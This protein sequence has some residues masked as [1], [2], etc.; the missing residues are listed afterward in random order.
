MFSA[1]GLASSSEDSFKQDLRQYWFLPYSR[2]SNGIL[3]SSAFEHVFLGEI[4][5]DDAQVVG[6]HNWV[7]AY[8]EEKD[9]VFVYG[10]YMNTCEVIHEKSSDKVKHI[11]T[12]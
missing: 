6:F 9:D 12:H 8:Y 7:Q 11:L 3:D 5:E 1:P 4:T 2:S 10:E